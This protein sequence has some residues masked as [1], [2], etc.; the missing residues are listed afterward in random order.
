MFMQLQCSKSDFDVVLDLGAEA[1]GAVAA[2]AEEAAAHARARACCDGR[3]L[4]PS[5]SE[6]FEVIVFEEIVI[7]FFI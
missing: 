5:G 6:P 7:F 4:N 1:R 2:A 3:E